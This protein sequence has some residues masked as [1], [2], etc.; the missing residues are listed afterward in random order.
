MKKK[1]KDD[2]LGEEQSDLPVN[3]GMSS[4]LTLM[5]RLITDMP[6]C[7]V[8]V[9]TKSAILRKPTSTSYRLEAQTNLRPLSSRYASVAVEFLSHLTSLQCV[10]CGKQWRE[11]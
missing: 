6:K 11:Y 8:A 10:E 4:I 5:E 2:I 7:L 1:Q 9:P 3:E